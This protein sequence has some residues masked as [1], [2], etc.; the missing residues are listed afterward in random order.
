MMSL[1][2]YNVLDLLGCR[3]RARP[4]RMT[5]ESHLLQISV[6]SFLKE[7]WI[8]S[9]Q[10][11]SLMHRSKSSRDL[12]FRNQLTNSYNACRLAPASVFPCAVQTTVSATTDNFKP[13][14][15]TII[16]CV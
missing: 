6:W 16:N 12:G 5:S 9:S 7:Y 11:E 8:S 15:S 14:L 1:R 4:A 13:M 10:W 2:V 3:L